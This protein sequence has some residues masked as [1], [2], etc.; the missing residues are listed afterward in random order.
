M[1][2]SSAVVWL[3]FWFS[4]RFTGKTFDY[5]S[6][7]CLLTIFVRRY[8]FLNILKTGNIAK[9]T[10]LCWGGGNKDATAACS[11]I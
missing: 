5:S 4:T 9:K 7:S 10:Y 6:G 3:T 2:G 1:I 11:R 8:I